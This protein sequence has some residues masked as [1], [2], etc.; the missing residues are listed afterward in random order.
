MKLVNLVCLIILIYNAIDMTIDFLKFDYEYKLFVDYNK[1]GIDLMPISVCTESDV[2]FDKRKVIK[3]LDIDLIHTQYENDAFNYFYYYPAKM[4]PNNDQDCQLSDDRNFQYFVWPEMKSHGSWKWIWNLCTNRFYQNYQKM[5][6]DEMS[7]DELNALTFAAKE[8][9]SCS[10]KVHYKEN[11]NI[12][13]NDSID[14]CFDKYSVKKSIKVN[15]EF[16]VCYTFFDK[17]YRILLETEDYIK[18]SIN[19]QKQKEFIRNKH[20]NEEYLGIYSKN[21]FR[22]FLFLEKQ[23]KVKGNVIELNRSP[24]D[25]TMNIITETN[26]LL[27]TPYMDFCVQQG[28][29]HWFI[30]TVKSR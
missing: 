3:N 12:K 5:V 28:N 9:F 23:N 30:Y 13:A 16:G 4:F 19:I 6:F 25:I 21:Y 26:E 24:S 10:A 11:T 15:K 7:F 14:N 2:L 1:D 18:I 29:L 27:S 20:F 17:N 22:L 8:L